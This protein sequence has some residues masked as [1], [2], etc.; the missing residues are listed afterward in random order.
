MGRGKHFEMRAA[1]EGIPM[2]QVRR[3]LRQLRA[4]L[5]VAKLSAVFVAVTE[6][7]IE[8]RCPRKL[9]TIITEAN[10]APSE[11]NPAGYRA[12]P[13]GS[14]RR[15]QGDRGGIQERQTQETWARHC[16]SAGCCASRLRTCSTSPRRSRREMF[17]RMSLLRDRLE[18][19]LTRA[20][21]SGTSPSPT[22]SWPGTITA[23]AEV[24]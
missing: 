1:R 5:H 12:R 4:A 16:T 21:T 15:H 9:K 20:G 11:A 6:L 19:V 23:M 13:R 8:A 22:P 18:G 17:Q 3:T 24:R 10:A 7:A 14:Q 2:Q